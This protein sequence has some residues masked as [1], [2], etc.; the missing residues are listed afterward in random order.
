MQNNYSIKKNK[1]I[2]DSHICHTLPRCVYKQNYV[3]AVLN[4]KQHILFDEISEKK[5]LR[6]DVITNFEFMPL[7]LTV[8]A[9]NFKIASTKF[10]A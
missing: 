4:D 2:Y 6:I 5:N 7:V 1:K 10:K 8:N 9:Q 3:F